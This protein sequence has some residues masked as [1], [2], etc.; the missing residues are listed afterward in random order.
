MADVLLGGSFFYSF[1]CCLRSII[2]VRSFMWTQC[3]FNVGGESSI[4]VGGNMFK[5]V[6]F[7]LS[8]VIFVS[9]LSPYLD[10]FFI[11]EAPT[12]SFIAGCATV[13]VAAT[14]AVS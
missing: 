10:P 5:A 6:Q 8:S 12:P 7:K 13:A 1:L 3:I 11:L 4:F 14:A 2:V 9:F